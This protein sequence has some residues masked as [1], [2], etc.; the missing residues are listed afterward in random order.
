MK[1]PAA[2]FV[3]VCMMVIVITSVAS[4]YKRAEAQQFGGTAYCNSSKVYDTNTNGATVLVTS[5]L[6]S[7]YICGFTISSI[8]SVNV[9]L[10]YG[11]TGTTC[12]TSQTKLT[13]A[14]QFQAITV[15]LAS[16]SDTAPAWRGITV[17]PGNDLCINTSAGNSVQAIVYYYQQR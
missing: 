11:T 3:I 14:F 17:P 1:K 9:S 10:V 16:V 2:I 5:G 15:G 12:A 4:I 7:I 8:T 6:G 13:P